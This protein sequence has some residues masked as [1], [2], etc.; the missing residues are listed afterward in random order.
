MTPLAL[1][2]LTVM[3]DKTVAASPEAAKPIAVGTRAPN[4]AVTTIDGKATTLKKVFGGKPTVLVFYRGGWC[5]FCNAHLADLG[6]VERDIRAKGYQIVAVTPDKPEMVKET[7]T[8][9]KLDYTLLSDTRAESLMA[10]GVAF[11]LDDATFDTYKNKYGLDL[12]KRS[13]M[14]HHILP[15]PSVFVIGA[16]GKVKFVHSNPDYRVRMKGAELVAA[17]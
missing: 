11:K 10:Y 6:Q 9:D 16:D 14:P 4:A 3:G 13:G 7:M 15:V 5:P 1:L 8:K 17:L 12:E 2:A